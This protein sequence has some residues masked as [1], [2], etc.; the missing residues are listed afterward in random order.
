MK[1]AMRPTMKEKAE[2][3]F[4]NHTCAMRLVALPVA[5]CDFQR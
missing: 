1:V 5:R 4:Q 3:S 2:N